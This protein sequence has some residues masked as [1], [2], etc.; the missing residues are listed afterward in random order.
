MDLPGGKGVGEG[1]LLG[2]GVGL[3]QGTGVLACG[4]TYG[5]TVITP[6]L[7][8]GVLGF[9]VGMPPVNGVGLTKSQ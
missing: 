1:W 2:A 6:G 5:A 7:G 3:I 8:M 4:I 9:D